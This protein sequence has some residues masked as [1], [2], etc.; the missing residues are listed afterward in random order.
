MLWKRLYNYYV[1]MAYIWSPNNKLEKSNPKMY[2]FRRKK[3]EKYLKK[4]ESILAK[5]LKRIGS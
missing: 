5:H 1:G 2:G 4:A 3:C